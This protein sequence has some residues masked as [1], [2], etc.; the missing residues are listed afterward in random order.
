MTLL[1]LELAISV[2][3]STRLAEAGMPGLG[4]VIHDLSR[5]IQRRK[6]SGRSF[7]RTSTRT[8]NIVVR[9]PGASLDNRPFRRPEVAA[10]RQ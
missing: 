6:G 4:G 7:D 8:L 10:L 2:P 3:T 5:R 9:S 1:A